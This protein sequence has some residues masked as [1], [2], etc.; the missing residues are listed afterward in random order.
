MRVVPAVLVFALAWSPRFVAAEGI[1]LESYTDKR[2]D[3]ATRLLAPLLEDLAARGY[4]SGDALGRRYEAQVS[5][6]AS[7]PDGLTPD[8]ES[9]VERG[10]KL[11]V[12]SRFDEAVTT[13]V[14][15]VDSAHA[16]SAAIS[17]NQAL[18]EK[19]L[20]GLIALSLS[21]LRK[22]DPPAA[23]ALFAEILRS[24][25]NAQLSRAQ[26]GPEAFQ[27]FEDTRRE[28]SKSGRGRLTVKVPTETAVVFID[29]HFENVGSVSKADMLPGEYRVFLQIGKQTSRTHRVVITA[30]HEATLA[31]DTAYDDALRTSGLGTGF[32][33]ADAA[34]REKNEP[35]FAARFAN[36][37]GASSVIVV[38]LDTVRGRNSIVGAVIDLRTGKEIRRANIALD[39]TPSVDRVRALGDFLAGKP[40]ADGLDVEIGGETQA[41]EPEPADTAPEA[42]SSG[43]H[44]KLVAALTSAGLAVASGGLAVKFALDGRDAGDELARTCAVSCTSEQYKSLH[45]QQD[46]DNRKAYIAGGVGV[47]FLATG[48]VFYVLSRRDHA[49]HGTAAVV[50]ASGGVYASYALSF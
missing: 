21:Q 40:A 13:L 2:P 9:G 42:P 10:F 34:A 35:R 30:D 3:D 46:A 33:F 22:G 38:G 15:L 48:A 8:F 19:L 6:P 43:S 36:E 4:S 17:Q 1:V 26:Y 31:V 47:A 5:R 32:E 12:A 41:T 37:L 28:L 24:F 18:Q 11:W 29:E 16:N 50:P 20:K 49:H 39:P 23:K 44:W 14:P 45:D 7:T 27:A 25:P